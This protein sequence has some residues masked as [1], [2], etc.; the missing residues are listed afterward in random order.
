[1]FKNKNIKKGETMK[2]AKF[3]ISSNFLE[4]DMLHKSSGI[5]YENESKRSYELLEIITKKL[6]AVLPKSVKYN[7]KK[8]KNLELKKEKITDYKEYVKHLNKYYLKPFTYIEVTEEEY[9]AW[10]K[11]WLEYYFDDMSIFYDIRTQYPSN[12]NSFYYSGKRPKWFPHKRT[13]SWEYTEAKKLLSRMK[14]VFG[15]SDFCEDHRAGAKMKF[16]ST[17]VKEMGAENALT[18]AKSLNAKKLN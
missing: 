13:P 12:E 11:Y 1:M 8:Y 14:N 2:T 10:Y 5:H 7:S 17:M 16:V 15:K 4:N 18:V 9:K 3:K 6:Y